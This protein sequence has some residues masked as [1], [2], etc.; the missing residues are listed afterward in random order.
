MT[1]SI[2]AMMAECARRREKQ[3]A[4]NQEHGI[5]PQGIV[6]AVREGIVGAGR[7]EDVLAQSRK[8]AREALRLGVQDLPK[9]ID[10]LRKAMFKAAEN[11]DF[12]RAAEMRDRLKELEELDLKMGGTHDEP[13]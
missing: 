4:H 12:E 2:K 3:L 10:Q 9:E 1:D 5:T 8:A 11:L 6:R 7:D 13:L